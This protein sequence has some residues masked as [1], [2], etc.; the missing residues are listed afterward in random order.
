LAVRQIAGEN[1]TVTNHSGNEKTVRVEVELPEKWVKMI[2]AIGEWT[3]YQ[4][5]DLQGFVREAVKSS[6]RADLE[7]MDFTPVAD[8]A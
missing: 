5:G 1:M 6:L 8:G 2:N 7:S 4:D 3:D